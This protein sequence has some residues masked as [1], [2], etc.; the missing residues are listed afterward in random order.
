MLYNHLIIILL[1]TCHASPPSPHPRAS[2]LAYGGPSCPTMTVRPASLLLG[3]ALM[4]LSNLMH[5]AVHT[6]GSRSQWWLKDYRWW[7]LHNAFS[8]EPPGDVCKLGCS[9]YSN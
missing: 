9:N 7:L 5:S 3:C 1:I 2:L 4:W 6:P 8:L